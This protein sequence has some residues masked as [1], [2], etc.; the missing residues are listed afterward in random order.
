MIPNQK[1]RVFVIPCRSGRPR[2]CGLRMRG[3]VGEGAAV[4]FVARVVEVVELVGGQEGVL[5]RCWPW[6]K[7]EEIQYTGDRLEHVYLVQFI[8]YYTF[9]VG[10]NVA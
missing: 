8:G 5:L 2:D 1:S 4:D 9:S 7:S 6:N 3:M 10:T